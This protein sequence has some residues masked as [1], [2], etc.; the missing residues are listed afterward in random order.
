MNSTST[1]AAVLR[2]SR[3]EAVVVAVVWI[4]ACGYTVG[5]SALFGYGQTQAPPL[6]AGIPAWVLWGIFLPWGTT[7]LFTCW[8]AFFGMKDEELGEQME[9]GPEDGGGDE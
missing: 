4:L 9:M 7:S 2:S 5:Y 3:R 1:V 8:F 6:I